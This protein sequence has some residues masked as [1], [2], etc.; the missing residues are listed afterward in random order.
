M[1]NIYLH[2][3]K[4]MLDM[5]YIQTMNNI[6][7]LKLSAALRLKE[8]NYNKLFFPLKMTIHNE[9]VINIILEWNQHK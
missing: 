7:D 6:Y 3:S 4:Y 9:Q 2:I 5:Q 8:P 1:R